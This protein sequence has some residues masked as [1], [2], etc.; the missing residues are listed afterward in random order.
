MS[1]MNPPTLILITDQ[2]TDP[3]VAEE[4]E[5]KWRVYDEKPPRSASALRFNIAACA[6]LLE[7]T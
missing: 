3:A 4:E 1:V 6:D 2:D 5:K 7:K